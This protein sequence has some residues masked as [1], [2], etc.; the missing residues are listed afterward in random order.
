MA[1]GA[2]QK[3]RESHVKFLSAWAKNRALNQTDVETA[4]Q[5][6][7]DQILPRINLYLSL[8]DQSDNM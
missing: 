4:L 6:Y 5:K 3:S 1:V 8:L 7:C 2:T